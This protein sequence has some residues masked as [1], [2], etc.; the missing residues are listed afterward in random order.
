MFSD[1]INAK[2]PSQKAV[3]VTGLMSSPW[4][5]MSYCEINAANAISNLLGLP[6]LIY[7]CSVGRREEKCRKEEGEVRRKKRQKREKEGKSQLIKSDMCFHCTVQLQSPFQRYRNNGEGLFK[8]QPR[9]WAHLAEVNDPSYQHDDSCQESLIQEKGEGMAL[10]EEERP[11]D[12]SKDAA[13]N[14]LHW[15]GLGEA[16]CLVKEAGKSIKAAAKHINSMKLNCL[17]RHG[18]R[19]G[20]RL[21]LLMKWHC[22]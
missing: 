16:V 11:Q 18:H 10:C 21:V 7:I 17:P 4:F 15:G 20:P 13:K 8:R 14:N 12:S 5:H 9:M 22:R 6:N 3:I 1:D 2:K 19:Q